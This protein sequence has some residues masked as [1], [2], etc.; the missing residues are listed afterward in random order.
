MTKANNTSPILPNDIEKLYEFFEDHSIDYDKAIG[1]GNKTAYPNYDQ[2][3]SYPSPYDL[4]KWVKTVQSIYQMEKS[5]HSRVASIRQATNG[6]KIT[7]TFDF[8]NWLRFYEGANHLKYKMAQ[9]WYENGAPGY[10][11]KINPD[12][13]KEEPKPVSGKDIDFARE[14][15]T[16]NSEKR[17]VIERQRNK[18]I[19]R[20]DSAE[21]LMR[22]PDGQMLAGPELEALMEAI[23]QLKKKI[24]LVNKLS[25]STRLYDD[26]I[27]R[28]ANI[29]HRNGF[30]KAA[31]LLY[32]TSQANNPPPDGMGKPGPI[33]TLPPAVPPELP[34]APL[35]PGAPGG[36][37]SMGPGMPQNAPAGTGVP[38]VGPNENSPTNID[39][40]TDPNKAQP[41]TSLGP[42]SPMPAASTVPEGIQGFLENME[43]G[44]IT[45]MHD[46]SESSDDNLEVQDNTEIEASEDYLMVVEGQVIPAEEDKITTSP[47]ATKPKPTNVIP[48]KDE[49]RKP[50]NEPLEVGESPLEVSNESPLEVSEDDASVPAKGNAAKSVDIDRKIDDVFKSITIDEI[51]NEIDMVAGIFRQREIPSRIARIDLMLKGKGLSSYFNTIG[52]MLQKSLD[53]NNYCSTRIEAVLSQLRG[54]ISGAPININEREVD[55]PDMAGIK[56]KLQQDAEK[57]KR[58]KQQRKEQ[59][60]AEFDAGAGKENA[61]EVEIEEDLGGKK[62]AAPPAKLPAQPAAA[63]P[64]PPA[65]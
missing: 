15:S 53:A 30:V 19:G 65:A 13:V 33:K 64:R 2:Y 21:K 45:T 24:Q 9:L 12:P 58:R 8:L 27:V 59:E 1:S 18:I 7:E 28:E 49:R 32:S 40:M 34:N 35:H 37:P 31:E 38:E 4:Q 10:F 17:Q 55:S 42:P 46:K 51:I 57:E 16:I 20:L 36:L 52:E 39:G 26:M 43:T 56:S 60:A 63:P 50:D 44:N 47:P 22:A 29:L 11:L 41:T 5:G 62:P 23:Y 3:M 6:W 54:S 14:E 25:T 48:K 61:P